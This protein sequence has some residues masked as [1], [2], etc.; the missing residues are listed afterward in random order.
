MV[1]DGVGAGVDEARDS[2]GA[3]EGDEIAG[4]VARE[5]GVE[6]GGKSSPPSLL[7]ALQASIEANVRRI[8]GIAS[9]RSRPCPR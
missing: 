8:N 5:V 2:G 7:A 1:A 4:A 3:G 6:G 9:R